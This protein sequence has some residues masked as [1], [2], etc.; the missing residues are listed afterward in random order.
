MT[1]T[2]LVDSTA[3]VTGASRGFGRTFQSDALHCRTTSKI[4]SF[5][6]AGAARVG[7]GAGTAAEP[8]H[9]GLITRGPV[10]RLE[11][12]TVFETIGA[13]C[14]RSSKRVSRVSVH[15]SVADRGAGGGVAIDSRVETLAGNVIVAGAVGC[16][17]LAAFRELETRLAGRLGSG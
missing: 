8:V 14:R 16:T 4:Y 12:V 9:V 11:R 17:F 1:K 6:L 15:V 2:D 10:T 3:L 5:G 7:N 13:L